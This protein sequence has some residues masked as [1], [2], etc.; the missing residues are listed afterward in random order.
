MLANDVMNFDV[1]E[2]CIYM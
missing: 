2:F 1:P